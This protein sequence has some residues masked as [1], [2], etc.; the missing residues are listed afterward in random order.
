MELQL[1]TN[2]YNRSTEYA[3]NYS[4]KNIPCSIQVKLDSTV[5][6]TTKKISFCKTNKQDYSGGLK[7]K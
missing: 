5:M 4:V 6:T 1:S 2:S 7:W 3:K